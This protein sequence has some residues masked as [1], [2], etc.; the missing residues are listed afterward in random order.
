MDYITSRECKRLKDRIVIL[1]MVTA[2]IE[3]I[4]RSPHFSTW[5]RDQTLKKISNLPVLVLRQV[6]DTNH[7]AVG[8]TA[9][10]FSSKVIQTLCLK[11]DTQVRHQME[12]THL[13]TT[14]IVLTLKMH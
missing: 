2:L 8:K 12:L 11:S 9:K 5:R 13:H 7:P 3:I 6:I 1:V 4:H 14:L 10:L